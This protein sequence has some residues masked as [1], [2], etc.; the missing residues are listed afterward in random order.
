MCRLFAFRS[1]LRSAVHRS[2]LAAENALVRQSAAHP[3]G[4]GLGYYVD[5]YPHLYRNPSQA[6]DDGIFRQVASLVSA[7]TLLAHIRRASVGSVNL[8]NC[9]PFQYG[10]WMMAHNGEIC[11]YNRF[12]E[13]R[14]GVR[15]LVA[16]RFHPYILG[17]TD[18]EVIFFAFLSR[19]ARRFDDIHHPGLP[20]ERVAEELRATVA[21]IRAV[22]DGDE[23]RPTR[24]T[25]IATNGYLML[26]HCFR[27]PLYFSS[28]KTECGERETCTQYRESMCERPVE[29]GLVRH[30]ILASET[31]EAG[32]NVWITYRA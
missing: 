19:L 10:N 28:H 25:L 12:A 11:G 30:L 6:L 13:V 32:P 4:W 15:A 8:L 26:G 16:P 18:S 29:E 3:D 14:A 5:G 7:H 24:L 1:S 27:R 2:L 21:D 22:H 17:S 20:F 23:V 9:H 31:L